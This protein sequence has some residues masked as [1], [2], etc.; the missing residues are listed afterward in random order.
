MH[1]DRE[2]ERERDKQRERARSVYWGRPSSQHACPHERRQR[3][4]LRTFISARMASL[5]AEIRRSVKSRSRSSASSILSASAL[6]NAIVLSPGDAVC[7][8]VP[9]LCT[10]IS[11]IQALIRG[12]LLRG[13]SCTPSLP[14]TLYIYVCAIKAVLPDTEQFCL[15]AT[16]AGDAAHK[17]SRELA[18][19]RV[20]ASTRLKSSEATV[21]A[22]R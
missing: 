9:C 8:C 2:R 7:V 12:Y 10:C 1:T 21:A 11:C 6:S 5:T 16:P 17:N 3:H 14:A 22:C 4:R 13:S 15:P 19:S 20:S 18:G